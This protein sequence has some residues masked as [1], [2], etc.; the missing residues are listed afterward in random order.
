[1]QKQTNKSHVMHYGDQSFMHY[2]VGN[3]YGVL[4]ELEKKEEMF[5]NRLFNKA[6]VALDRT[7]DDNTKHITAIDSR[8]AKM[9]HLYAVVSE[10]KSHRA[11]LD[12]TSEITYRMRVDHTFEL[13]L[14]LSQKSEQTEYVLPRNFECLKNLIDTY[15]RECGQIEDYALQYL[16]YFV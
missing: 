2:P 14:R 1:M 13:F 6:K 12:L 10:R 16:K 3:Y 5:F 8:D 7:R 9:H 15:E 11:Q 4:N